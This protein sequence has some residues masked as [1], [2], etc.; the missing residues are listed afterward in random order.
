M[1]ARIKSH[2]TYANVVSTIALVGF[3]GTGSAYAVTALD[4]NSVRTNHIVN[5]QVK[6]ADIAAGSVNAQKIAPNSVG[7]MDLKDVYWREHMVSIPDGG[8]S[9]VTAS[10]DPGDLAI[11]G[12]SYWP[13][14][15]VSQQAIMHQGISENLNSYHA[16][17][18]NNAGGPRNFYVSV[19]C[20][21]R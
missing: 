3:L 8:M 12:R 6:A 21:P 2:L 16:R 1:F 13:S 17:G 9:G 11:G 4:N 20:L 7:E 5:G 15:T 18:Y 19:V 14:L 10:C